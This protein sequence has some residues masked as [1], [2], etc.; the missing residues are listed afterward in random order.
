[1]CPTYILIAEDDEDDQFLVLSAFKETTENLEL[2]FVQN[3]IELLDYFAKFEQGLIHN[4]PALVIV[5]LNMPKKNGKEALEILMKQDYFLGLKTIV[6][7]TTANDLERQRCAAL[8]IKDFFIK[9]SNYTS[10]LSIVRQFALFAGQPLK[11]PG[12]LAL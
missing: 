1:M 6:F 7:S 11:E 12:K 9:P 2:I 5:D 3:G 10:L 8:G 4:L